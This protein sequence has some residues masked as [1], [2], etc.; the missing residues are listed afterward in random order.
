MAEPVKITN[1][2]EL[3]AAFRESATRPVL[4]LKHS[5]R[6]GAS[7]AVHRDVRDFARG[8]ADAEVLV[9]L[10]EIP[11][12]RALADEVAAR[13]GVKHESPQVLVLRDGVVVWHASHWRITKDAL[14]RALSAAP[15]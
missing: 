6:C 10:L 2:E 11:A 15:S 4:L 14:D 3:E 9:A 5:T 8:R 13:T 7:A 1:A 12:G